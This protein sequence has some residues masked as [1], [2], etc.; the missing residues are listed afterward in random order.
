VCLGFLSQNVF[1]C[2]DWNMLFTYVLAGWE[3]SANDGTVLTS[4]RQQHGYCIVDGLLDILDAGYAL[5]KWC[6]TPYRGV[7]YHL[8][9]WA[10]SNSRYVHVVLWPEAK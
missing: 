4:A 8:K 3:G 5:D 10:R 1:A 7:R 6:L 2:C 9:E